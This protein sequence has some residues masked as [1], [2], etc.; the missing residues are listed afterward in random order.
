MRA[1]PFVF[2]GGFVGALGCGG[3]KRGPEIVGN[4][5]APPP[6]PACT[7]ER[8]RELARHLQ[9]RRDTTELSIV[10]CT[11]GLF[12]TAGFY[13]E[14]EDRVGVIATDG[15][16]IV[17]FTPRDERSIATTVVDCATVD[18]NGDG[19]EE[20]VETWRRS[21]Q[22]RT[23]SNQWLEVQRIDDRTLTTITGR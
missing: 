2:V 13:I 11:P 21:A 7:E 23:G 1:L 12:P 15:T 4:R 14:T 19:V 18:L 22:G 17:P 5:A 20:I 10:R 6:K 16:D 8:Q 9:A 3:A